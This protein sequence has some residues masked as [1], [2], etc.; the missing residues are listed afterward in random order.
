[1]VKMLYLILGLA[2]KQ[3]VDEIKSLVG[4]K[5][6][7]L[8]KVRDAVGTYRPNPPL[9]AGSREAHSA[10]A[11]ANFEVRVAPDIEARNRV[12][13]R[14]KAIPLVVYLII[15]LATMALIYRF[16]TP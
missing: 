1:M 3:T 10:I 14:W 6:E 4:Q 9:E 11:R 12:I 8:E 13:W 15:D 2:L 16:D 7:K 5:V